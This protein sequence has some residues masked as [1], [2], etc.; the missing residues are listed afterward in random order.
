MAFLDM[1]HCYLAMP[2]HTEQTQN[3]YGPKLYGS[4]TFTHS[5]GVSK[6]VANQAKFNRRKSFLTQNVIESTYSRWTQMLGKRWKI[7]DQI[8][9]GFHFL[10]VAAGNNQKIVSDSFKMFRHIHQTSQ[11]SRA[12]SGEW[13]S[14]WT[15]HLDLYAWTQL[16]C[17]FFGSKKFELP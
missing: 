6:L 16:Q 9:I 14:S 12:E 3:Y 10:R 11:Q 1:P 7:F 15:K 5:H 13:R 8:F 4:R 2:H 17:T